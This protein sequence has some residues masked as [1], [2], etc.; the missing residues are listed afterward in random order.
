[1]PLDTTNFHP[2]GPV[3]SIDLLQFSDLLT[4][5]MLD[6]P[7][8]FRNALTIGGNQG[9]TTVPLKVYGATGQN[10]NLIDLYL[11]RTQ[12]QAGFG[13]SAIGA[14]AWG[15]GGT[16]P[17][18]TY[19]TRIALQN[20]HASD[21]PGLLVTPVLEVNGVL[22]TARLIVPSGTSGYPGNPTPVDGDLYYR[23]DLNTLSVYDASSAAWIG[24]G[25]PESLYAGATVVLTT[26]PY[27][28]PATIS[29][30]FAQTG[31]SSVV[32]PAP[33]TAARPITIRADGPTATVTAT[34]GS[35]V[36]GGSADLTTGA[37]Q[38]GVITSGEAF[39]YKSTG[40]NWIA[41]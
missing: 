22:R 38:N 37:V 15:P 9:L 19:L 30:V 23:S 6:Q 32:L 4:G 3:K 5:V 14:L 25:N 41:V 20:G 33:A 26:T 16:A 24:L 17:Q 18:D 13:L 29:Y 39:T 21:T 35:Q 28:V 10:T 36:Y 34:G 27:T 12:S 1:M 7:I 40:S 31:A 11:D 2:L 8:T